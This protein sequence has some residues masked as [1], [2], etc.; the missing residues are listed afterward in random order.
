MRQYLE[1]VNR[2]IIEYL[3]Q[4]KS[5]AV[6]P[7]SDAIKGLSK[8]DFPL[9]EAGTNPTDVLALLHEY[10]SPAT[11]ASAGPRYFGFVTGGSLPAALGA[12]QLA[13]AWDQLA[14]LYAASPVAADLE[15]VAE[16]WLLDVLALDPA[17]AVGFVTGA[18]AG[19]FTG[20]ATARNVLLG[21]KGWDVEDR[22][23]FGAPEIK[24]IV[25]DE[26]HASL[27][28]ALSMVGFGRERVV[29]VPV[30]DRGRMRSDAMPEVDD[31][32]V[33]CLQ[34]GNVNT[35]DFDPL[36]EIIPTVRARGAWVHVDAAFGLWARVSS[37][38]S[39]LADG[40][41]ESDSI[42]TDGH[43]WLNVPYDC[44]LVFVRDREALVRTMSA[45]A[46][47][48]IDSGRRENF[49]YVPEMSRRARGVEVWAAL[50]SLGRDGLRELVER[51][52]RQ[53]RRF[54]TAM[55]DSGY[56][57]LN[58]VVLNQ[59]LVSFGNPAKTLAVMQAVQEDGTL[60]VGGTVWQGRTAMRISVSSWATT[61]ED[62]EISIEAIL[63]IAQTI[64][65]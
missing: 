16:K 10:G 8:L 65:A 55:T 3:S 45:S 26:Y 14:G 33:V 50:L 5:R 54:A 46:S 56:E 25:G 27:K 20:L 6:A 52:C 63:R 42:A 59:V 53:A 23:L 30:D 58:E 18:T 19:N 9:P 47:Y 22:G 37:N 57:V 1:D 41:Q 39:H 61:D 28:K 21:R 24:V 31:M 17:S 15:A 11:V 62:V 7:T 40:I 43:K 64:S 2:Y 12:N 35:G 4:L 32:T 36:S 13:S 51:N 48:L 60:W 29:K 38:L 34:A 44:G 49:H